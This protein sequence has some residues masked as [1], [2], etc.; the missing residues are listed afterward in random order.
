LAIFNKDYFKINNWTFVYIDLRISNK[1][2]FCPTEIKNQ[3]ETNLTGVYN[4]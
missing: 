1:I 3:C 4:H 2:F